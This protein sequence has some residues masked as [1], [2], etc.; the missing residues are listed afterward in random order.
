MTLYEYIYSKVWHC[1]RP[2]GRTAGWSD[3]RLVG[4]PGGRTAGW[5]D[6]RVVG[7]PSGRTAGWQDGRVGEH[8]ATGGPNST[9]EAELR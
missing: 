7:R 1:R 9:A 4:R 8:N 6:G 2:G 5:S 3:G